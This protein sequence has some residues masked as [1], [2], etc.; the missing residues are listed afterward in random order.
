MIN[1]TIVILSDTS[2]AR[3]QVSRDSSESV[4]IVRP[5]PG[6]GG[7]DGYPVF[8]SAPQQGD[9]ISFNGSAFV[10]RVQTELTD[11]GNF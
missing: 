4:T 8:V 11:G 9:V 5:S 1:D 3:V 2:A 10:N 7:L 6:A